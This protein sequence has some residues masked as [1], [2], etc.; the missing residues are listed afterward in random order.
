[1]LISLIVAM[2]Q[3]RVIGREGALPWHL[4]GDLQR[5]KQLTMGHSLLMG[6]KTFESIGHPLPGRTTYILSRNP[7]YSAPGCRTVKDIAEAVELAEA[8]RESELFICGGE[9][10]YQQALPLCG[11]IYLT[12]LEREVKGDRFFPSLAPLSFRRT[13]TLRTFDTEP[14]RFSILEPNAGSGNS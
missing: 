10:L 14:C 5:F 4:P 9:R 12:E 8:A 7:K 11:R 2:A 6:R 1:M 13:R 3:N